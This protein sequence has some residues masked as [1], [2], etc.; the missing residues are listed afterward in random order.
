MVWLIDLRML[1][2]FAFGGLAIEAEQVVL[3]IDG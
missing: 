1:F 3:V 2:Y